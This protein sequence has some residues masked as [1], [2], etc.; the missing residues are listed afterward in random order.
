MPT[1]VSGKQRAAPYGAAG[2]MARLSAFAVPLRAPL[3]S[4][5]GGEHT[6]VV[7]DEGHRWPCFGSADGGRQICTEN[8]DLALVRCL[9]RSDGRAGISYGWT[10]ICHQT[11]NRLLWP[12]GILVSQAEAYKFSSTLFGHHG[13]GRWRER[14]LCRQLLGA[15]QVVAEGSSRAMTKRPG[16]P[17]K[18]ARELE[19]PEAAYVIEPTERDHFAE[20]RMAALA[21]LIDQHLGRGFDAGKRAR[22]KQI[23]AVSAR[24]Q[25]DLL[26]AAESGEIAADVYLERFTALIQ[27]TFADIDRVLGRADFERVFGAPP[28]QASG[29]VDRE[30]YAKAHGL[31]R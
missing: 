16:P 25:Y 3:F 30:A 22:V 5:V 1:L 13:L 8:G 20:D 12:A 6:Y 17:G 29:I 28:D 4:N 2:A 7:S 21:E 31:T 23:M 24:E 19:E 15:G 26:T 11:T 9:A 18:P 27:R 14:E 10:G